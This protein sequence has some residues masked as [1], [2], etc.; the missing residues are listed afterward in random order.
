VG[1]WGALL[2]ATTTVNQATAAS[3]I[4][5]TIPTRWT[6]WLADSVS[7]AAC[8]FGL[9][10]RRSM[11]CYYALM[12]ALFG[13]L[14]LQHQCLDSYVCWSSVHAKCEFSG[15]WGLFV[16]FAEELLGVAL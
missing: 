16:L 14:D 6:N 3:F 10:P 7:S 11:R 13:P 4:R 12:R 2:K 9:S 1:I 8:P 5:S 15:V